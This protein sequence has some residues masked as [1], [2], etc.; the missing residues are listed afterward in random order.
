MV[1]CGKG[2]STYVRKYLRGLAY[3]PTYRGTLPTQ[4]KQGYGGAAAMERG[5]EGVMDGW[6]ETQ[7]SLGRWIRFTYSE[8]SGAR[9]VRAATVRRES[10][11]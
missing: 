7:I 1:W 10:M 9:K 11:A 3:L 8:W 6:M 2:R 4:A 5:R